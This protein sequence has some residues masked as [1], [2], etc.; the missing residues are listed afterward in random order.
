M[1]NPMPIGISTYAFAWSIGVPGYPPVRPMNIHSF[2]Q[3]AKELRCSRVQIADNLPLDTFKE[4]DLADLHTEAQHLDLQIE[5]GMRGMTFERLRRYGEIARELSSPFLRIVID[6]P[7]FQPT[8]QEV[9]SHIKQF[10]TDQSNSIPLAIENHDRFSALDL[11]QIIRDTDPAW[12]GICLDSVNSLG[13]G[14]GFSEV[15]NKLLPHTLNIH[16]KDY[17]ITR[18]SHQMGFD[19]EGAIAGQGML[20]IPWLLAQV[21]QNEKCVSAILEQWPPLQSNLK[22]TIKLEEEWAQ[23]S[24]QYLI[25]CL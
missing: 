5:V 11:L 18:K 3:K 8:V 21:T 15:T 10:L 17:K 6:G 24:M 1:T 12:V 22:K 19:V 13:R 20:P 9:T 14:E 16:I 2:L 4:E 23:K 7:S 25:S